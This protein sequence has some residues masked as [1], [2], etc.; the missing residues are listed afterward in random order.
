MKDL[1]QVMV[2]KGAS[3]L[4]LVAHAPPELR[5]DGHLVAC[6]Y[7]SLITISLL[8]FNKQSGQLINRR[9]ICARSRT[10]KQHIANQ[11][12]FHGVLHYSCF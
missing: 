10:N 5:I 4:H 8:T 12:I 7:C 1:L 9:I 6:R 11:F 2:E 3:D